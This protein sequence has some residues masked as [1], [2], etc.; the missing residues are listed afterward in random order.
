VRILSPG[1][2]AEVGAVVDIQVEA[3]DRGQVPTGVREVRIHA[4]EL[5]GPRSASIAVLPGPGPDFRASW[6]LPPCGGSRDQWQIYAQAVDA[7]DQSA[8]DKVRVRRMAHSCFGKAVAAAP[9]GPA[10]VWTSELALAGGRGQVIADGAAVLFPGPGRTD[11]VL[12]ARPGRNRI[13]AVLVE[14]SGP[15]EWRFTLASGAIRAGTLRVLAGEAAAVGPQML[16]FRLRGRPGE[17]LVFAF[18]AE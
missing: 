1:N 13:E 17:R 2:N 15:G 16:L 14:G 10:L 9:A 12:P 18:E 11:L 7:C 6:T 5:G 4:E 3:H 8:I